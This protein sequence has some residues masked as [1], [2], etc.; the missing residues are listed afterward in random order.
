MAIAKIRRNPPQ[1][2]DPALKTGNYLNSVLALRESHA[3]GAD[4]AL[5]LDLHGQVTEAS[6]SNVF[7]V[8]AG[9]VVTPPL[10]V[11]MLEGVTPGPVTAVPAGEGPPG[12]QE[13]PR[14]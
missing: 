11:G 4:D 14:T 8:N 3:A 12:R 9:G 2:L 1:A 10:A 5:M 6:T 7:F 13:P